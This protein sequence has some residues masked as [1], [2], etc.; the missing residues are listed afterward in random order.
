[1]LLFSN[2]VLLVRRTSEGHPRRIAT[3]APIGYRIAFEDVVFLPILRYKVAFYW[4]ILERYFD[5][6]TFKCFSL[7]LNTAK[8]DFDDYICL[9]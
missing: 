7:I 6:S 3:S 2:S 5:C 8:G 9:P 1:M 4:S